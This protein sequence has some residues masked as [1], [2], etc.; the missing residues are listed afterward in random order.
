[1]PTSP[2]N[3]LHSQTQSLRHLSLS[4]HCHHPL[5]GTP[6]YTLDL[7]ASPNGV[8]LCD[9]NFIKLLHSLHHSLHHL[10]SSLSSPSFTHSPSVSTGSLVTLINVCIFLRSIHPHLPTL[11]PLFSVISLCLTIRAS[12]THNFV[13]FFSSTCFKVC[14]FTHPQSNRLPGIR[15]L[16]PNPPS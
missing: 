6:F 16:F 12:F 5:H 2:L 11:L 4:Q 8:Y 7:N 1:M 14:C 10:F 3:R 15:P 13:L 9:I